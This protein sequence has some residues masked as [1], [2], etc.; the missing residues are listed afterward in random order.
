MY[1]EL[2]TFVIAI[3]K[4]KRD[5]ETELDSVRKSR[6]HGAD[7]LMSQ[8]QLKGAATLELWQVVILFIVSIALLKCISF[9]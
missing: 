5:L 4:Q 6:T 8:R 1:E 2:V 9:F 7:S 3:E